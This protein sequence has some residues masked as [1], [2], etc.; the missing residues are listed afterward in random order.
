MPS[1]S[2]AAR[3]TNTSPDRV[4]ARIAPSAIASMARRS[5][6]SP[7]DICERSYPNPGGIARSSGLLT[8]NLWVGAHL[9]RPLARQE[10]ALN[11]S[12]AAAKAD[13]LGRRVAR[14]FS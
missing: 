4:S 7:T 13:V 8:R 9:G 11:Q 14:V 5:S 10:D 1:I 3:L 12:G 2:R 6:F